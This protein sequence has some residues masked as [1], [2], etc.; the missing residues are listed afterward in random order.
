VDSDIV[1][2]SEF[3]LPCA[4]LRA[5]GLCLY[6]FDMTLTVLLEMTDLTADRSTVG[7]SAKSFSSSTHASRILSGL[8]SVVKRWCTLLLMGE[9]GHPISGS[10]EEESLAW[11]GILDWCKVGAERLQRLES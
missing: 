5:V 10:W 11:A 2:I 8:L 4:V 3:R 6:Y 9:C 7:R 1:N